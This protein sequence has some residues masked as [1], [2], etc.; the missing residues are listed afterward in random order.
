MENL[1]SF[2]KGDFAEKDWKR[3]KEVPLSNIIM[4]V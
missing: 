3:G 1:I 4:K 2:L